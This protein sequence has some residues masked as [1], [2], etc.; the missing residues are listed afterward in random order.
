MN[1]KLTL[2]LDAAVI[3]FAH[4]YARQN[5]QSVSKVVENYF[6]EQSQ[7]TREQ[8]AIFPKLHKL[9]GILKGANIPDSK[10]ERRKMYHES[11]YSY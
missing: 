3:D 10:K 4:E 7:K 9:R 1:R 6:V 11:K 8:Q 2:S 5:Q